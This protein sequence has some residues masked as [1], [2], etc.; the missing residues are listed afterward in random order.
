MISKVLKNN[1]CLGCG[2]CESSF[3]K[4]KIELSMD[5][6]GYLRPEQHEDLSNEERDLFG[7]ICPGINAK[8]EDLQNYHPLWGPILSI[9]SGFSTDKTIRR[10]GSSGG[11]LTA[12]ASYLLEQKKVD[13]I[14]Q[15]GASKKQPYINEDKLSYTSK[16]V[17]SNAGSR[18]APSA[19]L[20]N[21]R[22]IVDKHDSI[23]V[24]GKPCD[25]V[26]VRNIIK[27]TPSLK[28]KIK[29]LLS[30]MCAGVPSQNATK[31]IIEKF[32]VKQDEVSSLKYRG[33]GWPGYFKIYDKSGATHKMSY[34]ESWGT[35]LNKEL[36][37]RCKVCADGT[38]EFADIT[39]A[40]AWKTTE[41]G[42]PSFQER[43]GE[44]LIIA[45]NSNGYNLLKQAINAGYVGISRENIS[46]A[47]VSKMQPYQKL[48]KQNLLP[49]LA[50]L[51]LFGKAV[52]R[53]NYK[54]LFV[55]ST[56]ENP[57][58]LLK[59]FV[60]MIKRLSRA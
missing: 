11:V 47:E 14:L 59:N 55:A 50:A 32:N 33:D 48:R 18:Y 30:F 53:Y 27:T 51:K 41:K 8:H 16:E 54:Q 34:N 5:D 56:R 31:K 58:R 3:G 4:N 17:L 1:L 36:Q 7:K 6:K 44:S 25:I 43:E 29:F 37:F 38:G 10:V 12:L 35:I 23:A 39:C 45:R 60:G 20:I 15:I 57:L 9:K 42:Y 28:K 49:R 2:A 13:C 26:G 24:I 46:T 40:D 19:T 22:A 21:I 52:P